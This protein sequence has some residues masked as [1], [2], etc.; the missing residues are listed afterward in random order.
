MSLRKTSTQLRIERQLAATKSRAARLRA[1]LKAEKK[2]RKKSSK[3][4]I[5]S[6]KKVFKQTEKRRKQIKRYKP[7]ARKSLLPKISIK[8]KPRKKL[9]QKY[10]SKIKLTRREK[11][12]RYKIRNGK[13]YNRYQFEKKFGRKKATYNLAEYR[14][15]LARYYALIRDFR[16][17]KELKG[18]KL[19]QREAMQH[20]E[21]K[22][23]LKDLHKGMLLKEAGK[24]KEGNRLLLK[25]LKKTTRRDGIP[26]NIP[27][28]ESPK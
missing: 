14:G 12:A 2:L 7:K 19:S 23:L 16:A 22:Q 27:V 18:I 20:P 4:I 17:K 21:M 28:G 1:Q 9:R 3:K 25:A 15:H 24:T 8:F 5:K 10:R 11:K 26:D 6:T 13:K